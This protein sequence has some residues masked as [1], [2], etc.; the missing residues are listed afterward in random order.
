LEKHQSI[1]SYLLTFL[2][3]LILLKITGIIHFNNIE[4]LSYLL[5]FF[6]LS[7]TFNSFG[8]NRKGL[9]FVSTVIF[10]IGLVLFIISNFE[11]QQVSRLIVPSS[12][13]IIG[14]GLLM[15][16]IEGNHVTFVFVLSLLLIV[17]GLIITITNGEIT[18]YSFLSSCIGIME[19]YWSVLLIFLGVF[20]LFRKQNT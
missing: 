13:M 6:G 11:I 4:L 7:Y 10:L 14:I 12:F 19:K 16:Y 20:F 8:N 3:I 17:A 18:I 1:I 9:L 15:T 5:I 2:L